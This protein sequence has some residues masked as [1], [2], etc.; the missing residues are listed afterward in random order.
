MEIS[1][2][3]GAHFLSARYRGKISSSTARRACSARAALVTRGVP[4][5]PGAGGS[6]HVGRVVDPSVRDDGDPE[7]DLQLA[8]ETAALDAAPA[9]E[10]VPRERDSD[11]EVGESMRQ[12][13]LAR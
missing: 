9:E 5:S 7:P 4:S 10:S 13:L 2:H 6:R 8:S 12:R 1:L 11:G 3:C